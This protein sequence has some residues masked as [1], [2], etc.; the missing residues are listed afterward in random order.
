MGKSIARKKAKEAEQDIKWEA[1]LASR[2]RGA[3][4]K[5]SKR[6]THEEI[7]SNVLYLDRYK[8]KIVRP[9]EEWRC[10]SYNEEKQTISFIKHLFVKY[11]VP[12]F[13]YKL[14]INVR[15]RFNRVTRHRPFADFNSDF[16]NWFFVIAQ[17]GSFQKC[18]KGIMTKKEAHLFLKA[19]NENPPYMN[20]WWAKCRALDISLGTTN[21]LLE[22]ILVHVFIDDPNGKIAGMLHFFAKYE[23]D[24]DRDTFNDIADFIRTRALLNNDFSFKGRTLQ[25]IIRLSN[26]WH[27]ET[28]RTKG[29]GNFSWEGIN[30]ED[31]EFSGKN[32]VWTVKQIL[33]TK[34]LHHEGSKQ[35]HCVYSYATRCKSGFSY[36]FTMDSVCKHTGTKTKH[37]TIELDNS[38]RIMQAKGKLNRGPDDLEKQIMRRWAG[39]NGIL[40]G[41]Y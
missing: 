35:R 9:P 29:I 21:K 12:Y 39:D 27:R 30:I 37:I 33:D 10:V 14:F 13:M 11:P 40:R 36:I 19:P 24:I 28:Q 17:G 41:Y 23:K 18:V 7:S 38:R 6:K 5:S 1:A 4:S 2:K 34:G 8:Q 16:I 3:V 15:D 22:R 31:W 26:E 32:H 20:V 25:S